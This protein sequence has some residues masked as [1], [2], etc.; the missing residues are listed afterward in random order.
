M[1]ALSTNRNEKRVRGRAISIPGILLLLVAGICFA[2]A[3]VK[4]AMA[5][6]YQQRSND[7]TLGTE[8]R[9]LAEDIADQ[10][11]LYAE[12]WTQLGILPALLG[13]ILVVRRF[14]RFVKHSSERMAPARST[15]WSTESPVGGQSLKAKY[16][17]QQDSPH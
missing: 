7:R 9:F 11:R 14:D 12:T 1:K 15:C 13:L 16:R 5:N 6:E 4:S 10:Q 3:Y 2:S 8:M 17:F